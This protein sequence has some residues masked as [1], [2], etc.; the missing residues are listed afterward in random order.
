MS[1]AKGIMFAFVP[2]G[3][4]GKSAGLPQLG[5]TLPPSREQLM[6][7]ALMPDIKND[8]IVRRVKDAVKGNRQLHHTEVGRQMPTGFGHVLN[9]KRTDFRAER[10]H[11]RRVH[12]LQIGGG[13][14][15]VEQRIF[16]RRHVHGCPLYLFYFST[17]SV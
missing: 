10:G 12:C 6:H 13:R 15:S 7:I 9:Q 16:F 4:A 8:M 3:K 5:K 11:V 2:A 14:Y 17:L 1:R